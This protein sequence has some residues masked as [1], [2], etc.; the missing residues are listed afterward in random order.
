M[1]K[2]HMICIHNQFSSVFNVSPLSH[3]Q[4]SKTTKLTQNKKWRYRSIQFST[5]IMISKPHSET[6][7]KNPLISKLFINCNDFKLNLNDIKEANPSMN[8]DRA[9]TA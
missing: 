6:S 7:R 5:L 1:K 9:S 4:F 3:G 8:T 2:G